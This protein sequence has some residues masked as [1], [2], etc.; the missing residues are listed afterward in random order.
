MEARPHINL[1]YQCSPYH[2]DSALWP[3]RQQLVFAA[4][5]G[6]EDTADMRL[7]K[8]EALL[9]PTAGGC[10]TAR[11]LGRPDDP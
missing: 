3:V 8:I 6:A 11:P 7:D 4:G 2:T 10:T 1:R 9:I 5:F